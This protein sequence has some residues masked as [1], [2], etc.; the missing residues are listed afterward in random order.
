MQQAVLAVLQQNQ[1]SG[2]SCQ[3]LI[4][5]P[6]PGHMRKLR[7]NMRNIL[8]G[9]EIP[10]GIWY[11]WIHG[12]TLVVLAQNGYLIIEND[13]NKLEDESIGKTEAHWFWLTSNLE[14]EL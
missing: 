10:T 14:T 7:D 3:V 1:N 2:L 13:K 9:S 12:S 5:R 11:L 6:N 8:G 4:A